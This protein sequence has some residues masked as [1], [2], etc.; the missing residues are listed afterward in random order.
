M[1]GLDGLE[2][3]HY[4][5]RILEQLPRFHSLQ[6]QR[7]RFVI[8]WCSFSRPVGIFVPRVPQEIIPGL[9]EDS[10]TCSRRGPIIDLNARSGWKPFLVRLAGGRSGEAFGPMQVAVL[11]WSDQEYL[12]TVLKHEICFED[13]DTNTHKQPRHP[14]VSFISHMV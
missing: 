2:G 1:E 10:T 4:P 11:V 7:H 6:L 5:P 13:R 8:F 3:A 14:M 9:S 12:Q